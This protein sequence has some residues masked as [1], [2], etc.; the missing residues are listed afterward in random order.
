MKDIWKGPKLILW[1]NQ[2]SFLE[3]FTKTP[4]T[5]IRCPSVTIIIRQQTIHLAEDVVLLGGRGL[6]I[7]SFDGTTSE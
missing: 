3:K 1:H 7:C 2:S 6:F 4:L 5:H